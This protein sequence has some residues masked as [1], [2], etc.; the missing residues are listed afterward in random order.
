MILYQYRYYIYLSYLD[1]ALFNSTHALCLKWCRDP[2]HVVSLCYCWS[3]VTLNF[4]LNGALMIWIGLCASSPLAFVEF[5]SFLA[6]LGKIQV[7]SHFTM[8]AKS[9]LDCIDKESAGEVRFHIAEVQSFVQP[10]QS[11]NELHVQAETESLSAGN[12]NYACFNRL[13][14]CTNLFW[15]GV[16]LSTVKKKVK[17]ACSFMKDQSHS[18]SLFFMLSVQST[19]MI[20]I[21]GNA[22]IQSREN[23]LRNSPGVKSPR[24]QMHM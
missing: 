13:L 6:R 15:S 22:E 17:D 21:E 3:Q 10:L 20:M 11:A 24:V 1:T 16:V 2:F 14:Y 7:G 8:V 19:M 12:I 23:L 5:G 18:N 4:E 9:L